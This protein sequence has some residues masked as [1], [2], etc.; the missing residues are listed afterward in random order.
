MEKVFSDHGTRQ[1]LRMLDWDLRKIDLFP[2]ASDPTVRWVNVSDEM[3][4]EALRPHMDNPNF[5]DDETAIRDLFDHFLDQLE[6]IH[7][8]VASRLVRL[9]DVHPYLSY[10]ARRITQ[11]GD[12]AR[13]K[14]LKEYMMHYGYDGARELLEGLSELPRAKIK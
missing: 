6:R 12:A 1:V 13:H 2:E 4:A 10:W 5:N 3:V 8:I 14:A 9:K 11:E 7:S